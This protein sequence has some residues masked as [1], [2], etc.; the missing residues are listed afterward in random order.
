M[1]GT[2]SGSDDAVS[3]FV[4]AQDELA[5]F[6]ERAAGLRRE[7]ARLEA[8]RLVS[9]HAA[10]ECAARHAGAFV[11]ARGSG[12]EQREL[13][14][15]AVI[16]ELAVAWRMSEYSMQRLASE[17]YTLC[18][19]LPVTLAALRAGAVDAA[20]TR[21][22]VD[23][24]CGA[25]LE[26]ELLA[27]VETELVALA[28]SKTPSELRRAAKQVLE[29][30]QLQ[31]VSERHARA[32]AE[33]C[34]EVE[35][36]HDGMAWLSLY[37]RASDALLV[38]DRLR[39]AA[40]AAQA[41]GTEAR[42]CAQVEADLARDL[43]L[44]GMLTSGAAPSGGAPSGA[45]PS[46]AAPTGAG[47]GDDPAGIGG[48]EA[49]V[50]IDAALASIRPT[51]HVTVPVF[52]LL[53]LDDAPGEL[54]G[55]GPIDADTARRL[56][57][58]APS[59]TR[60]LTHPISGA[61][62][63]VDRESY[64]PPADLRRWLQVRDQTCRFP[65]CTRRAT[66]CELDHSEDWAVDHGKTAH[67]NLA[68]LCSNHHHLK[69]DTAWSLKHLPDGVLEWT[70]LT[71]KIHRTTPPGSLRAGK[72]YGHRDALLEAQDTLLN[73]P[74]GVL[75]APDQLAD[76]PRPRRHA[77]AAGRERCSRPE[78][79]VAYPSVPSF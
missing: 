12:S 62:L 47:G 70:S 23:A 15:R 24:V 11:V 51:V 14:R 36:S 50:E 77:E 65:G 33:R 44:G 45:A 34:V 10:M 57:A 20:Q 41:G 75:G 27:S 2:S 68:H 59:F 42:T 79:P 21:V 43:L 3:A 25:N 7:A 13:A 60:L 38:R 8:A 40:R 22:I 17:A 54:D 49:G 37:V 66:T 28:G 30:R 26:P 39:Q 74:D 4:R 9:I 46:G 29:R 61:V 72:T 31:T 32:F 35:P 64:R 6:V 19:S 71:G 52:T 69:H 16:A 73:A 78:V 53:G 5:G 58:H 48:V 67:D 1:D 18:T 63:D 56:V 76:T 55:Y